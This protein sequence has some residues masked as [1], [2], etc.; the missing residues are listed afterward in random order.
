MAGKRFAYNNL[1]T[2]DE[3]ED[4]VPDTKDGETVYVPAVGKLDPYTLVN[5]FLNHRNIVPGL[6]M[7]FGVYDLLNESPVIPQAYNGDYAPI[8]GRSREYVLKVSYQI[9]FK[10]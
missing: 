3:D 9:N 1:T 8:P 4:G 2:V 10:K 7:G 6:T 5:V